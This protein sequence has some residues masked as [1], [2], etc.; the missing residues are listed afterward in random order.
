[1]SVHRSYLKLC[2]LLTG[3]AGVLIGIGWLV[4][5]SIGGSEAVTAMIW[6]CGLSWIASVVSGLPQILVHKAEQAPGVVFLGSTAIRMGVTLAGVLVIA[7]G[8]EISTPSFLLWVALSYL[9]FLIVDVV[10]VLRLQAA[11]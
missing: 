5:S 11:G 1:M 7:L 10:F 2:L 4:A 8:T 3:V 6:G 9:L